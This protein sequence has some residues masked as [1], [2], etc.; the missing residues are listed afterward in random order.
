M[1]HSRVLFNDQ[2]A[3]WCANTC[4]QG[5]TK[6]GEIV[7]DNSGI[8]WCSHK[9]SFMCLS[10]KCYCKRLE[11]FFNNLTNN[12]LYE[13]TDKVISSLQIKF[14][15][16]HNISIIGHN[17]LV[18]HCNNTINTKHY[19]LYFINCSN[20][21]IK[22]IT[23]TGCG[24]HINIVDNS[25][26]FQAVIHMHNCSD[27]VIRKSTFQHCEVG[28]IIGLINFGIV[29]CNANIN[30]CIFMNNHVKEYG[31]IIKQHDK[32]FSSNEIVIKN[33]NFG[34]NQGFLNLVSIFNSK[35]YVH[36]SNFFNNQVSSIHLSKTYL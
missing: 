23:W 29:N 24:K 31:G 27:V 30:N 32:Q 17:N 11:V 4:Y 5:H 33:C 20:I 26:K 18:V 3:K 9:N 15:N 34:Y 21:T 7:I 35:A 28:S 1:G 13:I 25:N 19:R 2:L 12:T 10:N 14:R 36:N 6:S 8:V 16:L 22:G